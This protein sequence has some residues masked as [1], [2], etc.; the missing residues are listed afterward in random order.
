MSK[1]ALVALVKKNARFGTFTLSS[2]KTSDFYVDARQV[3]L[4]AEGA[5]L[6]GRLVLE[7]LRPDVVAVG[8]MTLGA[9]PIACAAAALSLETLGRP[10]HA[11]LVRK[12]AKAH[13]TGNVVEGLGN[14]APG[15]K[16]CVVEDTTTSGGSLLKA[17]ERTREAG[18]DVVQCVTVVDREEGAADALR[19][20]GH[21][22]EA[23]VTRRELA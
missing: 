22:L 23:L 3:T 7:R 15:S 12:E 1:A 13:G 16:V 6:V 4:H 11:F 5:A 17:I 10:I 9:D 14:L 19:A 8:G 2:G 18:L 20:A 21:A